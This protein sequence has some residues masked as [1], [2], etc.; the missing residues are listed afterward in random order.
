MERKADWIL[1]M[2]R[3][4][5]RIL[6]MQKCRLYSGHGTGS[7]WDSSHGQRCRLDSKQGQI[8]RLDSSH[9]Q[10]C[11]LGILIMDR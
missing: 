1:V 3:E 4:A 7:K 9:G 11:R 5:K 8:C 10:R 6:V 2:Y